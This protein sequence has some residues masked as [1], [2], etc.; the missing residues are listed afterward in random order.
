MKIVG[1]DLHTRYQQVAMLDAETGELVERRLEHENGEARAFYA[2]LSS[3]VRVG[4]EAT[5]QTRWFERMLA[6]L[7]H[8]LWIGDAA[9][10][11]ASMVRKQKTDARDAAH[12]LDLLL[13]ERFPR[14]RRPTLEERDLRQLVWH[15]QK[16]VWMRNAAGNQLHALAMGEGVCRKKKL[17]TKKGRVELESLQ[18]GPWASHRRQELLTMTDQLD[19]SLHKLDQAVA[20]QAERNPAAGLLMSH[21]GAGAGRWLACLLTTP[22]GG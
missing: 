15:R 9:E 13:S 1:C 6:E 21:P 7:G 10:I 16:L 11:R 20:E 8:E 14:I 3:P 12:L 17:F 18:L 4:I 22:P 2:A 5:G 19:A